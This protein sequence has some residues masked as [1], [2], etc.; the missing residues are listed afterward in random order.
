M[1]RC[2]LTNNTARFVSP[3]N[4]YSN[5][6]MNWDCFFDIEKKRNVYMYIYIVNFRRKEKKK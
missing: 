6:N 1:S 5:K 2:D 4:C 3:G